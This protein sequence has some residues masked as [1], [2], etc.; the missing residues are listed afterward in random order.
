MFQRK[1]VIIRSLKILYFQGRAETSLQMVG[2]PKQICLATG[3][4]PV[5][6][7]V[8]FDSKDGADMSV[9][10]VG[11]HTDYRVLYPIKW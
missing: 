7:S 10:N 11:S 3:Y 5:F 4:T 2:R 8:D 9:R 1:M 6:C